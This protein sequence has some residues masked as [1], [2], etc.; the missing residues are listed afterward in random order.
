MALLQ[1]NQK[2]R[3]PILAFPNPLTGSEFR[4]QQEI[5][6]QALWDIAQGVTAAT[7]EVF[8]RSLVLHLARVMDVECAFLGELTGPD[9]AAVRTLA[10]SVDGAISEN[11]QYRLAGT[12]CEKVVERAACFFP[13]D[14]QSQFPRDADLAE[15]K[16]ES[17]VGTP[18][19]SSTGQ[20]LGL[21][22]AMSR[23][24]L[25]HPQLSLA[26]MQIFAARAAA[27]LERKRGE[28][29]LREGGMLMSTLLEASPDAIFFKDHESRM[30]LANQSTLKLFGLE[31]RNYA[32]KTCE[33]LS[34][35]S[36][37][38]RESF[39]F[40]RDTDT[41]AWEAGGATRNEVRIEPPGNDARVLD[42]IKVPLFH[43]DGSR[44]GMVVIGRDITVRKT[45]EDALQASEERYRDL[46]ENANDIIYTHHLNGRFTSI[47][48][49]GERITGY[50]RKQ[51]LA[52]Q[53]TDVVHP[54]DHELGRRML[55]RKL[56]D[57]GATAYDMR[58]RAANGR[59][60]NLEVSTRLVER[61]SRAVAVQGIARDT[62]ERK[63]L[64]GQ[65]R[66]AQKMEAVG[67]LAGG[68]AHDFNNLLMV[69]GGHA[70]MLIERFGEAEPAWRNAAEIRKATDRAASL[71]KQLLAFSRKQVLEPKVLNLHEI[72]EE[73]ER[74][75]RRLI[76]EDIETL[77]VS[78]PHL[79]RVLAD[80][81]QIEQVIM[82]LAVNARDA[83]PG[84]GKLILE[85]SNVELDEAYV[86]QHMGS[87]TGR[88]VMLSVSDTG[89]GMD[90]ETISHVFEPFFTTKEIGKG[91]GLGLST[92]YGIVK[93]SGGYI[94]VYSE[95]G[96]GTTFKVYLPRVDAEPQGISRPVP[97]S[98]PRGTETVLL[99]EDE[100]AVREL[101]C[102]LLQ[103]SGYTVL[104]ARTPAEALEIS[105]NHHGAI[106]LLLTDVVMPQSSGR[107]LAERIQL[108]RAGIK[109]LYMSG[110]TD[111]A[112]VHHGVLQP[113]TA[114]LQK[115]FR[116][117][118]LAKKMREVLS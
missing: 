15:M 44:R 43:A 57:G 58:I 28:E 12:P 68:V 17:Y 115:P 87:K 8:F 112:I 36:P 66:Q 53:I 50:S 108:R 107:D 116:L 106:D 117:A 6:G 101:A 95:I 81:G 100:T 26:M 97:A 72:V 63:Q 91:T 20:V 7:G 98:I 2:P 47:N 59:T 18:L 22:G 21:I 82:N 14:V 29:M 109:V 1:D 39:F 92:V 42:V 54:E 32:G 65:L 30:L 27:E 33:E 55:E 89:S 78:E 90:S 10:I 94:T 114:F 69:I 74:M 77:I 9:A 76:G 19:I 102:E 105:E 80:P 38:H 110:Y 11:L 67:R 88:Y 83:M 64:E 70:D 16:I 45:T 118:D 60:V 79:G 34:E 93:Q 24:P 71:T 73:T 51:I 35:L 85:T 99:V 3:D 23:R 75:L 40:C 103:I 56:K 62:T 25:A 4:T 61:D 113:G 96:H 84:G 46:F 86:R 104:E 37:E 41:A 48:K 31:G 111:D 13:A 52:M 5:A 49:T